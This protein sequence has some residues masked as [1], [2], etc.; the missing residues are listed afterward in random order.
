MGF[1]GAGGCDLMMCEGGLVG[2]KKQ[3]GAPGAQFWLA[4]WGWTGF[5]VEGT[6]MGWGTS[7]LRWKGDAIWQCVK[8]GQKPKTEL[9]GLGFGQQSAGRL[10]FG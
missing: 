1:E 4:M 9:Q 5:W 3:N 6:L 8:G 2:A 10:S 7:G